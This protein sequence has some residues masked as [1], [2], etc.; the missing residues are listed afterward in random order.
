MKHINHYIGRVPSS[1]IIQTKN[2]INEQHQRYCPVLGINNTFGLCS[3]YRCTF[4]HTVTSILMS[5]IHYL[6]LRRK[7]ND[8]NA[9][10]FYLSLNYRLM[11][12]MAHHNKKGI[13]TTVDPT[14]TML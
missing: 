13:F 3:V 2:K 10:K 6:F 8:A 14:Q 12:G 5:E 9:C 1:A 4:M 11:N 7:K